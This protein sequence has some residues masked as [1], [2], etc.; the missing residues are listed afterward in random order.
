[1]SQPFVGEIRMF[2]GT[3]API[4]WMAC[5]GQTL[6][7]SDYAALFNLIGTTYGGDGATTFLLPDL[8][9]RVPLHLG[10]GS[11]QSFT[12]GET[13]GVESVNLTIAQI[14]GHTHPAVASTTASSDTPAGN[15][16]GGGLAPWF[17]PTAP[18]V[19]L[20]AAMISSAGGSQAHT[21][22][23]PYLCVYFIISLYGIY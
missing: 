14:P 21:N 5:E 20:P 9:G 3:F 2:G 19:H 23:Q 1:M 4:D 6:Q 17:S 8:R 15:V 7:I 11:P 22:F 13:G 16:F 18:T 10:P 12:I